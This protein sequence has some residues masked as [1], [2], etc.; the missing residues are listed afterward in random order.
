MT[1]FRRGLRPVLCLS[2]ALCGISERSSLQ[3]LHQHKQ[4]PAVALIATI[5]TTVNNTP[6]KTRLNVI[7]R[8]GIDGELVIDGVRLVVFG[9]TVKFIASSTDR[10]A[11]MVGVLSE[12][13]GVEFL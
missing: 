2:C 6:A 8:R 1:V 3:F 13:A 11:M 7:N 9:L 10:L 4:A 12:S 5:I